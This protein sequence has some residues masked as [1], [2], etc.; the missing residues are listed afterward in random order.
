MDET[1]VNPRFRLAAFAL[2]GA[3][4]FIALALLLCWLAREVHFSEH[5]PPSSNPPA[6]VAAAQLD[7]PVMLTGGGEPDEPDRPSYVPQQSLV[8]FHSNI[9]TERVEEILGAIGAEVLREYRSSPGLFLVSLPDTISV[10]EARDYLVGLDEVEHAEPN[11]IYR[12]QLVPSDTH[13]SSQWALHNRGQS[14]GVA[15][16]DIAAVEGW[17]YVTGSGDVILGVID[18]GIDYTHSDLKANMWRNPGE[19]AGNGVDD[20]GNGWVDDVHGINAIQGNGSPLDDEGHGTHVAGSIAG[21]G[22]DGIGISG[23]MWEAKLIA[24]KFLNANGEGEL[25]HA[26]TCMDYFSTLA[27]AGVDITATN[28]SWGGGPAS[29]LLESAISGHNERGILFVAAAGNERFNLDN[30]ASY[31]ASYDLPNVISVAAIDSSGSLAWFSNW[32][33]NSVDIA[34]PGVDILSAGLGNTWLHASGTSMAAPHVTGILGLAK[35]A[36]PAL[37]AAELK[38]QLLDTAVRSSALNDRIIEGRRAVADFLF[39][40]LDRDGLNDSWESTYGLDPSNPLDAGFDLDGDGLSNRDEFVLGTRPDKQ[41]TDGDNLSDADE[42]NLHRSDP[43]KPDTDGDGLTDGDEVRV[44][45]TDPARSDTDDDGINDRE[46]IEFGTDP[47]DSDSD[48]DGMADGWELDFGLDPLNGA[49]GAADTDGDGLSNREEF[50]TGASP[51]HADTDEDGLRDFDEVNLHQTLPSQWDTDA[52][53]VPD[54]WEVKYGLAPLDAADAQA[55]P[56]GDG[57]SNFYEYKAGTDPTDA[58]S[59]P[60]NMGWYVT[61][62]NASHNPVSHLYTNVDEF[63]VRWSRQ[64]PE[65][66]YSQPMIA[67]DGKLYASKYQGYRS[68]DLLAFSLADGRASWTKRFVDTDRLEWPTYGNGKLFTTTGYGLGRS[69]GGVDS[70][71]GASLW[72]TTLDTWERTRVLAFD[73]DIYLTE[74]NLMRLDGSTGQIRWETVLDYTVFGSI[75]VNE[76]WVV[77]TDGNEIYIY[78]ADAGALQGEKLATSCPQGIRRLTLDGDAVY[79][80]GSTCLVKMDLPSRQELWSSTLDNELRHIVSLDHQIFAAHHSGVEI[81]DMDTG[82]RLDSVSMSVGGSIV[83]TRNHLFS[84]SASRTYAVDLQTGTEVWSTDLGGEL[85]YDEYGG[86]LIKAATG[87]VRIINLEGDTDGDGIPNWWERFH[88]LNYLDSSDAVADFDADGLSN[89]VEFGYRSNPNKRDTDGDKLSDVDE[90]NVHGTSPLNA[91]TDLDG[92]NDFDEVVRHQTD[93]LNKDTDGDS[94]ID[95]EEVNR[96]ATDPNDRKSQPVR[97]AQFVESFE[98]DVPQDWKTPVRAHRGWNVDNSRAAN[99]TFSLKA[100]A[101]DHDQNAAIELAMLLRP[102]YLSFKAFVDS[103]YA[104]VLTLYVDGKRQRIVNSSRGEWVEVKVYLAGG[105]HR[106]RWEYAK[107]SYMTSGEDSAWI[108]DVQFEAAHFGLN[109]RN[110]LVVERGELSEYDR[111]GNLVAGPMRFVSD[112]DTSAGDLVFTD[113]HLIAMTNAPSLHLYNPQTGEMQVTSVPDWSQAISEARIISAGGYLLTPDWRGGLMRFTQAGKYVDRVLAEQRFE[114]ISIG[115]DGQ[116]YALHSYTS[117]ISVYALEDLV[118]QRAIQLPEKAAQTLAVKDDGHIFYIN[119]NALIKAGPKGVEVGRR[120]LGT[121]S[122]GHFDIDI[123]DQQI[124]VSG[125]RGVV[126]MVYPDLQSAAEISLSSSYGARAG[127]ASFE[128]L[129]TD[130]DGLPNWWETFYEMDAYAADGANRDTDG[131]GLSDLEEFK[132]FSNP[133]SSDSDNDGLSDSEEMEAGSDPLASDSDFDGLDDLFEIRESGTS[134][135]TQDTDEDGIG[136]YDE[137]VI[138]QSDPLSSDSDADGLP[139]KW[140]L[141]HG[142]SMIDAADASEDPDADQLTNLEEFLAGTQPAKSDTD[143]DQLGDGEELTLGTDPRIVDSDGDLLSDGWEV[144]F[145]YDPLVADEREADSDGDGSSDWQEY[146][147][148]SDPRDATMG[149]SINQWSAFQGGTEYRGMRPVRTSAEKFAELWSVQLPGQPYWRLRQV[150][151]DGRSAYAVSREGVYALDPATGATKWHWQFPSFIAGYS[152]LTLGAETVYLQTGSADHSVVALNKNDGSEFFS[153]G[154]GYTTNGQAPVLYG[155]TL[156]L[157]DGSGIRALTESG[158]TDWRTSIP[159]SYGWYPVVKGDYV[160]VYAEHILYVINR[161]TR[162]VEKKWIDDAPRTGGSDTAVVIG[163][164]SAFIGQAGRLVRID[165]DDLSVGWAV[166][167]ASGQPVLAAGALYLTSGGDVIAHSENTG[168]VLWRFSGHGSSITGIVATVDHVFL[169]SGTYTW[170]IDARTGKQVWEYGRGGAL[171]LSAEGALYIISSDNTISAVKLVVDADAD[172]LPDNWEAVWGL[173]STDPVDA[174][175]DGDRDGLSNL[176]EYRSGTSPSEPD[177]DADGL[178][179]GDEV[180]LAGTDPHN[181]DSDSDGLHDGEEV[182]DHSSDPLAADTDRDGLSDYREVVDL[183]TSPNSADSDGDRFLDSVEVER[184]S[185]PLDSASIPAPLDNLTLDFENGAMPIGWQTPESTNRGWFITDAKSNGGAH[186]IRSLP[187]VDNRVSS[188]EWTD[189]FAQSTLHFEALKSS[190]YYDRFHL[191]VDS[192]PVHEITGENWAVYMVHLVEGIH[193]IRWEYSKDA[194]RSG[195]D[196]AAYIDNVTIEP[197]HISTPQP[198]PPSSNPPPPSPAPAPASKSSGG[199]GSVSSLWLLLIL[200]SVMR[201]LA[202]ASARTRRSTL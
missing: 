8:Q 174:T 164:H 170:A 7:L 72:T 36:A 145:G 100:G 166:D 118:E 15:G 177:G 5:R 81:Y 9:S 13:F 69:L 34:A 160:Y 85:A 161:H 162:V 192:E 120:T 190:E 163:S 87:E 144:R 117:Q 44:H 66:A 158:D 59:F 196:D 119:E 167:G 125:E 46:E 41:D 178:A 45:G 75:V 124:L 112:H 155:S 29:S 89:L 194:S 176:Q 122:T 197:G 129:D 90:V 157:N 105:Y 127:V 98:S 40:D 20:D 33:P 148:E 109:P 149:P 49:D 189:N 116:L 60:P 62:A 106:L 28:N 101:I 25:A 31:P 132:N 168:E 35:D 111:A 11:A 37:T 115:P 52:D 198:A 64:I 79:A 77:A 191:Y 113:D 171:S 76:Q 71:T 153:K 180:E 30:T 96:Y 135:I 175:D 12:T 165:L 97:I 27:D 181:S 185:D 51:L 199:G 10:E 14:G 54:G 53:R 95:G 70:Q 187:I 65:L 74:P 99:G 108:D 134:P 39:V 26:L 63:S 128:G 121:F 24:C 22:N 130:G 188:L 195:G 133:I 131:D 183:G 126:L 186:V 201:E 84:S 138:Y 4:V 78:S 150:L 146:V 38:Q 82:A 103:S 94:F 139:D 83:A 18:T 110:V 143:Y 102:G 56:D 21:R 57:F 114:D 86:L 32:G 23:V 172:G 55:D 61:E 3:L 17:D 88:R 184:E 67:A 141:D 50:E 73:E 182:H 6:G 169:S 154:F 48:A 80:G 68:E 193:T 16:I 1:R 92:L 179:D 58:A 200:G 156:Y 42:V 151:S 202:R 140:E 93:P 19:I 152:H 104:D 136:D 147:G 142:F 47:V 107:D 43:L 173:D 123:A 2:V 159:N 91:D 137:V